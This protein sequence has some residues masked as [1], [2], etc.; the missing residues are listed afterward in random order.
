[1]PSHWSSITEINITVNITEKENNNIQYDNSNTT[2]LLD[3]EIY[4]VK[5]YIDV[6]NEE[7]RIKVQ[8]AMSIGKEKD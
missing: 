1:M 2:C 6:S 8:F 3:N 5:E 4:G 7:D